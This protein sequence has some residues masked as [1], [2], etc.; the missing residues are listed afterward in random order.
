SVEFTKDVPVVRTIT[1]ESV[2]AV[3]VRV[4]IPQLTFQ[5]PKNG[6]LLGSEVSFSIDLQSNGGGYQE[7]VR[8]IIIGK[9]VSK[10]E[11]S[12]RVELTGEGPWDIRCR[13]IT[14]DSN[15][16]NLQNKTVF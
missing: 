14:K 10:Y 8:D 5:N 9:C 15:Q 3:R 2:D 4:S 12:Y 6:D 13:R 7:V 11:R 1:N 16:V